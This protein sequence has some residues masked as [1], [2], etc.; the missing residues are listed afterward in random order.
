MLQFPPKKGLKMFKE[1]C[2]ELIPV[3]EE[4]STQNPHIAKLI[5]EHR[6][7]NRQIDEIEKG[8]GYMDPIKLEELKKR[9]LAIKDEVYRAVIA[10]KKEKGE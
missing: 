8:R 9:K 3:M 7:L 2:P 6:E 1:C 10:F 5:E 4:L